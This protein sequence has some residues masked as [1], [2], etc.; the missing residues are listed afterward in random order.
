[1]T[2][3][4]RHP[5]P[6]AETKKGSQMTTTTLKLI[7]LALMLIDHIG[8]FIPGTPLFLRILGRA[9]APVFLFCSVWTCTI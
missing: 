1:M 5:L 4:S 8:E 2:N 7:A 6:G 3:G 9:S